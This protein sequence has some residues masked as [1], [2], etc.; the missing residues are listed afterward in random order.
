M[1]AIYQNWYTVGEASIHSVY[2][3]CKLVMF[4]P[5]SSLGYLSIKECVCGGG[6]GGHQ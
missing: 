2:S 4:V 6:G 1:V 5:T 3:I